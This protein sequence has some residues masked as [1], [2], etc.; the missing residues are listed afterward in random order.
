MTQSFPVPAAPRSASEGGEALLGRRE[1]RLRPEHP[2][3]YPRVRAGVWEPAAI[4]CDRVRASALLRGS[5]PEWSERALPPEHFEFRGGDG[6]QSDRP[7]R[8]DR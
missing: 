7:L 4:L 2:G 5:L 3:R 1:G 6:A 8:E